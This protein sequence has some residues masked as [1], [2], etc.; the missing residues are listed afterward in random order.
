ML[1]TLLI[2]YLFL[3]GASAGAC[4][5]TAVWNILMRRRT[6]RDDVNRKGHRRR[7]GYCYG[8]SAI[9][10]AIAI[11][12]LLWDLPR[13]E[14]ALLLFARPHL[15]I[16]SGGAYILVV[17]LLLGVVLALLNLAPRPAIGGNVRKVLE[18]LS[19]ISSLTVMA[20]PGILLASQQAV[21]FWNSWTLV[22]LFFFSSLSSGLALVL[23]VIALNCSDASAASSYR[24]MQSAHIASLAIEALSLVLFSLHAVLDSSAKHSLAILVS[25]DVLPVA[26]IGVCGFAIAV[27]LVSSLRFAWKSKHSAGNHPPI[28]LAPNVIVNLLCLLGG[29][30]LRW[31]VVAC[32]TH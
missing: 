9:I 29:F 32:G 26:V 12:C 24:S 21:P 5:S 27:P 17:E 25:Q 14:R 6:A 28:P 13:P 4:L 3:G 7:V 31:C 16:L 23:I 2:L 20:Y 1:S 22:M 30:M 18:A 11:G 10:L 15:T 8:V 19:C